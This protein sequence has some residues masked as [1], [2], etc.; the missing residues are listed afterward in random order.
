MMIP[1]V[2]PVPPG[3]PT[4]RPPPGLGR[5][6]PGGEPGRR[7]WRARFWLWPFHER[8]TPY[9]HILCSEGVEMS[10]ARKNAV[11]AG[12]ADSTPRDLMKAIVQDRFGPPDTLRMVDAEKPEIGPGD[13]LLKVHAAA[14]NPFAGR[15][16]DVGADVHGLRPGDEVF[17][18]AALRV[19]A[20]VPQPHRDMLQWAAFPVRVHP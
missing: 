2:G 1:R 16:Q 5:P 12:E 7:G 17:G 8:C 18:F 6:G 3:I 4:V 11:A 13:V 14:V 9:T 19:D 20:V 10:V 15:V